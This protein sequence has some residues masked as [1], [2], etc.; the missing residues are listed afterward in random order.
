MRS[1]GFLLSRRWA[2]FA[3]A[4]MVVATATWWLG[5]WQFDR[6]SDRK[7]D[8]RIISV[9]EH[10][11][12]ATVS[13]VLAVGR[14]VADEDEWRLVT[15]TGT[16]DVDN[17][18]IWRYRSNEGASG[19]DVVV[20]LVTADGTTLLVDRGWLA[21]SNDDASP[22]VPS[23][24]AGEVTVTGYVRG[25]GRGDSTRVVDH[26][27]RALSSKTVG[28]ALG[29]PVFG[30][31]IHLRSEDPAAAE[32]LKAAELPDLGNGPHFFYGLQWWFFGVLAL[33]GFG[34][35]LWDEWRSG[36]TPRTARPVDR[37]KAEK[38]A[39]KQAVRDAY[40]AAYEKD[41]ADSDSK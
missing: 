16:Y 30:G 27:T 5:N 35:L 9:N 28:E 21:A 13:E 37:A 1:F 29:R 32:P 31:W 36:G 38:Q 41:R 24:P 8:N 12:P 33:F 25:D 34:Y 7:A 17:T 39:R 6:L 40:K 23:P 15:A 2:L 14:P 4:V 18:I 3:L 10:R 20:P 11:E 22:E 19:V 26:S